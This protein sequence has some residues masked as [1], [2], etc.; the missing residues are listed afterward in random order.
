[1]VLYYMKPQN[2]ASQAW[3][4]KLY[5]YK[6]NSNLQYLHSKNTFTFA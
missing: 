3:E 2:C 5:K 6:I 1:M 4:T